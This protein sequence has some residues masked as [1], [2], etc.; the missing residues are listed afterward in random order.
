[1]HEVT[2]DMNNCT[3]T[4]S[5]SS[6]LEK[7][8]KFVAVAA[9]NC[10]FSDKDSYNIALAVDEAC[11]N[12]IKYAKSN[13]DNTDIEVRIDCS[14]SNALSVYIADDAAPFNPLTIESPDMKEYLI[15][16]K[17]GGLGIHIMKLVMDEIKYFPKTKKSPK[18]I[19]LLKK[20]LNLK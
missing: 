12:L 5:K 4:F 20:L 19:L 1:V 14:D 8:R 6:E 16:M 10:G 15:K 9:N 3:C 18:N 2:N 13:K 17:K 7:I 11:S